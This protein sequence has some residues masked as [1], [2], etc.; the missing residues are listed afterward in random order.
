M[1][2]MLYMLCES[3]RSDVFM[4]HDV[5]FMLLLFAFQS[6]LGVFDYVTLCGVCDII[7]IELPHSTIACQLLISRIQISLS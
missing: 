7:Q 5:G 1:L 6:M 4:V 3:Q 2:Y